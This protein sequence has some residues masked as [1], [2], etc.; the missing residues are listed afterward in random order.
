MNSWH[1]DSDHRVSLSD[2]CIIIYH[3]TINIH[4]LH[5]IYHYMD[6]IDKIYKSSNL[7]HGRMAGSDWPAG[8]GHLHG[9]RRRQQR[10]SLLHATSN[11][12]AINRPALE[13]SKHSRGL[14][15]T[16][17]LESVLFDCT[18]EQSSISSMADRIFPAS[19]CGIR[20]RLRY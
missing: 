15:E 19:L 5:E 16:R 12:P 7:L 8:K 2:L 10:Q 20:R 1:T 18:R 17:S 13:P 9:N 6:K 3:K 4:T 11:R 14:S